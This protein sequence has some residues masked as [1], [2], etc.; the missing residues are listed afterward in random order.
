LNKPWIYHDELIRGGILELL[1]SDA[2]NKNW[3]QPDYIRPPSMS[4]E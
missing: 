3:C 2:P 4:D 1:M